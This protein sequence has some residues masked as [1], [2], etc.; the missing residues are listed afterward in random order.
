MTARFEPTTYPGR[1]P[2]GAVLVWRGAEHLLDVGGVRPTA[3]VDLDPPVLSD[4]PRYVLAFGSN[5]SPDRLVDKGLD[6][7]GA[8]LL[9]ADVWGWTT[10]WEARRSTS[11]G[12]VPLTLLPAPGE[13]LTTWVLGVHPDDLDRLDASE[14]RGRNYELGSVGDVAVAARWH[15]RRALAF[16]P[17]PATRVLTDDDGRPLSAASHGQRDAVRFL[18]ADA[19]A[20]PADPLADRVAGGWPAT[21]LDPLD[22]LV[23]G[24]LRP[25]EVRWEQIADLVEV[26]G[27][28]RARG[29]VWATPMGWPAAVFDDH[30]GH[31][32]HGTLLRPRDPRAAAALY[33]RVDAIEGEGDLFVRIAVRVA[34]EDGR[35]CWAAA[36]RWHPDRDLPPGAEIADGR[37]SSAAG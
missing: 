2:P 25:G 34:T 16:G 32:V 6:H 15:L 11:T 3:A 14:F 8:L 35:D 26:V 30:A 27:P 20:R 31:D 19:A 28:A 10:A 33:R 5:A 37:W 7:R 18:E 17:G 23:Y 1:R 24:T 9:P 22:L 13:R 36:Y 12:A 21:P 29:R 4:E